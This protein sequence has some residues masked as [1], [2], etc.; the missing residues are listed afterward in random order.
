MRRISAMILFL[1]LTSALLV[2][3]PATTHALPQYRIDIPVV[4]TSYSHQI[5]LVGQV[6]SITPPG[7]YITDVDSTFLRQVTHGPFRYEDPT[8]APN[9]QQIAFITTMTGLSAADTQT[10]LIISN[11]DGTQTLTVTTA[12]QPTH[13]DYPSW[14]PDGSRIAYTISQTSTTDIYTIKPDGS[15]PVQVTSNGTSTRPQWS[16]DGKRIGFVSPSTNA[17]TIFTVLPDGTDPAP[18][19]TSAD[20]IQAF[21]W[22]PDGQRIAFSDSKGQIHMMNL[23]DRIE[24]VVANT[25]ASD[26]SWSQDGAYLAYTAAVYKSIDVHIVNS[27]GTDNPVTVPFILYNRQ[28]LLYTWAAAW[29]PR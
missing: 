14:S 18:L 6:S 8:W 11:V 16:P 1:L 9:G 2:V 19:V 26:V 25:A 23:Q 24:H 3:G 20:G 5:A 27:D 17:N 12:A 28:H 15:Q 22:S 7:I 21:A 13:L 29:S 4:H 10:A